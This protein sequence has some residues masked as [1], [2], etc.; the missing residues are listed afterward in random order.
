MKL[1]DL[2]VSQNPKEFYA[3]FFLDKFWVA[4]IPRVRMVK[5]K[6]LAQFPWITFPIQSCLVLYS[7]CANLLHSLIMWL[8]VSSLSPHNLH[9]LFYCV[10]SILA[11][12]YLVLMAL[13]CAAYYNKEKESK[14]V[15][16][17]I[18][19]VCC[20]IRMKNISYMLLTIALRQVTLYLCMHFIDEKYM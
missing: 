15:L 17:L 16:I 1:D 8:I 20:P 13:F 14:E 2:F 9:Q 19:H 12:T 11:L 5:F 18:W 3:S 10:L 6:L 7:L 4:H